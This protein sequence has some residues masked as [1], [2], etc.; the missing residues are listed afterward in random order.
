ME[1][2]I[3]KDNKNRIEIFKYNAIL[4]ILFFLG[5]TFYLGSKIPNFNLSLFTISQMSYFLDPK[6]L[7]YF[8]LLFIIKSFMDLSFT[9][10][11]FKHFK[12]PIYSPT[13]I[14][15]LIAVLSFGFLGFFPTHQYFE[16]HLALVYLMFFFWT[17]SEYLFAKLTNNSDFKFLTN[18]L[19]IVQLASIILFVTT[20]NFNGVFE[21]IYMLFV[22]FWLMVF[23]GRYLK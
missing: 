9:Y 12:L 18:N 7:S 1:S 16:I 5:S 14:S 2:E 15:W 8:N 11:V 10:F 19:L 3:Q 21:I 4:S 20:N 23:I 22:F 17:L 6:Q 13:A